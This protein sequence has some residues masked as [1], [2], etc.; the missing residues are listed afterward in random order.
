MSQI[1]IKKQN[2]NF[3]V[4]FTLLFPNFGDVKMLEKKQNI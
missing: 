2:G 3:E 1:S 4:Y